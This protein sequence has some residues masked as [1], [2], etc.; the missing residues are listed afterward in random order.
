MDIM[1]PK[2]LP[3]QPYFVMANSKYYKS[4]V[5]KYGISH[6][7]SFQLE[8]DKEAMIAIPDGCIDI[9]FCCD[10]D[11]PDAKICG[12]VLTPTKTYSYAS[13]Y[14]FGV[15]FLPGKVPNLCKIPMAEVVA[16]EVPLQEVIADKDLIEKITESQDFN[17]QQ[18]LFLKTYLRHYI[19]H[20]E[21]NPKENLRT[22]L[23]NQMILTAGNIHVSDLA[24][25]TGYTERYINRTFKE[26]YG[27]APKVFCKMMR[28]QYLLDNLD[29]SLEHADFA[30]LAQLTGYYDQS[31][32]MKDFKSFTKTTPRKY[33]MA[34]QDE[35]YED[36]LIIDP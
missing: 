6:F 5:L 30:E 28:F 3:K 35:K 15:R 11:H 13:S 18:E 9:L 7:Y 20:V 34:L 25:Q 2:V 14:Y 12:T 26:Y 21:H 33:L 27:M 19:L 36:R 24:A 31:H 16:Q 8:P 10:K 17:Y 23:I 32:M 1:K 22:Y 29:A 4:V